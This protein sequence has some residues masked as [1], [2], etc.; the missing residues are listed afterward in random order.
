MFSKMFSG[1]SNDQI[2]STKD[3]GAKW[4]VTKRIFR[5]HTHLLQPYTGLIR[6]TVFDD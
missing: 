6:E 4:E 1:Y 5:G 3:Y 2:K